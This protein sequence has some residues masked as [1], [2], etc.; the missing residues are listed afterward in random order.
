MSGRFAASEPGGDRRV[1]AQPGASATRDQPLG[2]I[3]LDTA[4]ARHRRR[5]AR[6]R[7]RSTASP[8]ARSSRPRARTP[9]RTASASSSLELAGRAPRRQP[10]LRRG[11]PGLSARSPARSSM[12]VNAVASGAADYVLMHRALHNPTGSY[13]GNPMREAR[14]LDAVDRA[15]GLLRPAGDDRAAVQRVPP[16]LRRATR[17]DGRGAWSRRA[18]TARASRGRAG[19]T[20]R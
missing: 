11:L 12:A 10:A 1:R 18:R 9:S 16:A 2:A 14:G 13:H 20:A 5:R 6:R 8:P 19:T 15:A 3:A 7:R 17:I 4:R